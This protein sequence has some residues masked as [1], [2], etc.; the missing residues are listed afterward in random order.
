MP[1]KNNRTMFLPL[2][3]TSSTHAPAQVSFFWMTPILFF[4]WSFAHS[5][6]KFIQLGIALITRFGFIIV[7]IPFRV[8]FRKFFWFMKPCVIGRTGNKK[9]IGNLIIR[10]IA[11]YVVNNFVFG[12]ISIKKLF[13][14]KP[15]SKV[16]DT[17]LRVK[18]NIST[19]IKVSMRFI[20]PYKASFNV[21]EY[22]HATS[23]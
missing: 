22:I 2:L 6:F 18:L 16:F 20:Y 12:K 14:Y 13:H 19:V 1:S 10:F 17:L 21:N 4:S 8:T 5:S 7:H 9:K 23:I 11:I 3:I 15:M